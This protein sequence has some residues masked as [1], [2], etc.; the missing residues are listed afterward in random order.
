MEKT[1][2]PFVKFRL[3]KPVLIILI[4]LTAF[5]KSFCQNPDSLKKTIDVNGSVS[6]TNNG[7]GYIPSFALNKPAAIAKVTADEA[8]L[9]FYGEFR[10]ALEGRPWAVAFITRYKLIN[11]S[12][13]QISVGIQFPS[14][15][16]RNVAGVFNGSPKQ[17][18]SAKPGVAPEFR[19]NF[20]L[21]DHFSIG[22]DYTYFRWVDN[23]APQTGHLMF[24]RTHITN[25]KVTNNLKFSVE[26]Q[27]FYLRVDKTDGFYPPVEPC[28]FQRQLSDRII[29]HDVQ[30]GRFKHWRQI[31]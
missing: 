12:Q 17:I 1:A 10:Y 15:I 22:A 3:T 9:S 29:Q 25:I 4:L 20:Q 30:G 21:S 5:H 6:I 31:F 8:N 18:L 7:F 14:I 11:T 23:T 16:F 28:S 24:L 27:V 2:G 19:T 13:E 26:P